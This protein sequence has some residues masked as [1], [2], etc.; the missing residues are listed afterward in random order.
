[1]FEPPAAPSSLEFAWKTEKKLRV[2]EGQLI[3]SI[4]HVKNAGRGMTMMTAVVGE[5]RGS[6]T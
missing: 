1:M 4:L 6:E 5:R 3:Q 2:R